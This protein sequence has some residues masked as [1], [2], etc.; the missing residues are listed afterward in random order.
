M[1][2]RSKNPVPDWTQEA[3]MR[4]LI[5][6]LWQL[7]MMAKE[8]HGKESFTVFRNTVDKEDF[9]TIGGAMLNETGTGFITAVT[10]CLRRVKIS[11][12]LIKISE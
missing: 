8:N 3:N 9:E 10:I 12:G 11:Q 5:L 2:L 4:A 1:L 7:V 6:C